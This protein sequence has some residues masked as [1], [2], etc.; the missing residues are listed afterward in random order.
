MKNVRSLTGLL[1]TAW[2]ASLLWTATAVPAATSTGLSSQSQA[3][4]APKIDDTKTKATLTRVCSECHPPDR[5]LA[6]RRTRTQWEEVMEEMIAQ[7]A[8][9][10]DEE[11][12]EIL[13]WLVAR[14]GRVY[15]NIAPE[16]ELVEVLGLTESDAGKIVSYRQANGK[17]ADI[18][19]LLKVPGITA[20]TI[21]AV[22]DSISF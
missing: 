5:V 1:T 6:S 20:D 7:G 22:K 2:V 9:M 3:E 11:Y 10:K 8:E 15:V 19:A 16:D 21:R 4:S 13:T 12:E 18:E 17:F 14:H